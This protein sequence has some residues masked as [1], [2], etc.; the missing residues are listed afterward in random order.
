MPQIAVDALHDHRT[1]QPEERLVSGS[2]WQDSG[3]VFVSTIGTALES[4]NLT[5]HFHHVLEHADLPRIRFHDLRH[6]SASL[7][8]TQGV[9]PRVLMEILGPSQTS[10][11][12]DTYAHVI[13]AL[14]REAA[15]RTN[16]VLSRTT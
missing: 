10:L 6:T 3:L 7:L 1:R 16:T 4:R 2:S 8:L 15:N 12:M 11:T 14:E 13:P 9:H 5:R